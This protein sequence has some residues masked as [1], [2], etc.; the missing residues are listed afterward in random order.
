MFPAGARPAW[1]ERRPRVPA[2][3]HAPARG[4]PR[5]HGRARR[6][7]NEVPGR[8]GARRGRG[9]GRGR[10]PPPPCTCS[11][12]ARAA[13]PARGARAHA[14]G[15]ADPLARSPPAV[16]APLIGRRPRRAR[17]APP[18]AAT[19]SPRARGW[20][21][22]GSSCPLLMERWA[23]LPAEGCGVTGSTCS[24]RHV[25]SAQPGFRRRL[26]LPGPQWTL[27]P[28]VV[29]MKRALRTR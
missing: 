15:R 6:H 26:A 21:A 22:E 19:S 20:R 11:P 8:R 7:A 13:E 2:P 29:A 17:P 24:A 1:G 5:V 3:A 10:A 12:C 18:G 14:H 9:P 27:E 23:K 4:P 16:A 25:R 28:G